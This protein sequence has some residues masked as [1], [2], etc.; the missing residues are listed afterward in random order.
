[1]LSFT[2]KDALPICGQSTISG[3]AALS[4]SGS[5]AAGPSLPYPLQRFLFPLMHF[6]RWGC[7]GDGP[8]VRNNRVKQFETTPLNWGFPKLLDPAPPPPNPPF[9]ELLAYTSRCF[10]AISTWSLT[11][12]VHLSPPLRIL[13]PPSL[14]LPPPGGVSCLLVMRSSETPRAERGGASLT[15]FFYPHHSITL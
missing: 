15:L 5:C 8:P 14:L 11:G 3:Q 12:T 9:S 6:T 2:K 1:M 7:S 13:P 4:F 10:W